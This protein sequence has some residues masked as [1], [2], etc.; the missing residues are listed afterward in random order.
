MLA[1]S[2]TD[3]VTGFLDI[4]VRK[5]DFLTVAVH[6]GS[7]DEPGLPRILERGTFPCIEG[8]GVVVD[9]GVVRGGQVW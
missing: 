7:L 6:V 1:L 8:S 2:R 9:S 3:Q 5:D 4:A